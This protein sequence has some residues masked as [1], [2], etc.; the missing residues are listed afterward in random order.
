ML[1]KNLNI[2]LKERQTFIFHLIYSLIEGFLA[3]V[4]I[5]NEFVF[6][7]SLHGSNY[8]LSVLF[9][10]S[11][12][13]LIISIV[14][15]ELMETVKNKKNLLR[16][17]AVVTRLPLVLLFLFP[18]NIQQLNAH[19]LYNYYF[20]FAFF[21]YYLAQPIILPS[22]NLSLKNNYEHNNF[23]KLYSIATSMNK[24]IMLLVTFLFGLLLDYDNFAFR[25]IYPI[26]GLMGMISIYLL[27]K[28]NDDEIIVKTSFSII[29]K[30]K[31]TFKLTMIK[32][33]A[34]RDFQ[35]SLMFYGFGYMSTV[36]IITIFYNVALNLNYSSVAFYKNVY[37]II[38]ILIL[39]YFG[40]LISRI[41]QRRFSSIS[42]ASLLLYIIFIML[43]AFFPSHFFLFDLKIYYM[44]L[45]AVFFNSFFAATMS[46]SWSIGSAY[47][48]KNEEAGIYQAVHLSLTGLRGFVFPLIGVA[49]YEK[50]GFTITYIFAS[51]SLLIGIII[52]FISEKRTPLQKG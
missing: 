33:I 7:K 52:L 23:G 11:V 39:P 50:F 18:S 14:T 19:P 49:L 29:K 37:N 48:C 46:L 9:Q 28:I 10:F 1:L 22:L 3:G 38:A 31:D 21:M 32:N 15:N 2:T 35:I 4:F 43:T 41:D 44:L 5:L 13:V 30:V 25:Y 47:F 34:H 16:I 51:V 27:T 40:R 6:I 42:I 12:V 24:I 26:T 17:I 20:L 36:T 45:L 8:Q